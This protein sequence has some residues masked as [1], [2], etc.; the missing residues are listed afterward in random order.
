MKTKTKEQNCPEEKCQITNQQQSLFEGTKTKNN[1]LHIVL[2]LQ[3]RK[4]GVS[5][6]GCH[7]C[8]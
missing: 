8:C 5:E 1:A 7:L 2:T 4:D 6:H 3:M